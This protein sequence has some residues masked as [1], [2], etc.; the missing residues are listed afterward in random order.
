LTE[1]GYFDFNEFSGETINSE[2]ESVS[3]RIRQVSPSQGPTPPILQKI[4]NL[5]DKIQ[6]LILNFG[7]VGYRIDDLKRLG[8]SCRIQAILNFIVLASKLG[9]CIIML[10]GV[11]ICF[12][13]LNLIVVV[14]EFEERT[15]KSL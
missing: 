3:N 11:L 5:S 2:E 6:V 14:S 1:K 7:G 4:I 10:M 15:L 8:F 9:F 13:S 12:L